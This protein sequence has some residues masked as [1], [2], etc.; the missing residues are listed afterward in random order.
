MLSCVLYSVPDEALDPSLFKGISKIN[1][2]YYAYI[3]HLN[4][5]STK[6]KF[7]TTE[8]K[9]LVEPAMM[10]KLLLAPKP[11]I[12]SQICE[13]ASEELPCGILRDEREKV[14]KKHEA[15]IVLQAYWRGTWARKCLKAHA[16]FTPEANKYVR[17]ILH[18]F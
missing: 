9:P 12:A 7:Q 5:N 8:E 1:Y 17:F 4:I 18:I 14:I 13:L 11:P 6:S 10:E 16:A 15:A 3:K 2:Y